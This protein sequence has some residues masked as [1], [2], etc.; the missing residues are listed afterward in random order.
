[1][2]VDTLLASLRKR[3]V[4]SRETAELTFAKTARHNIPAQ[5]ASQR[6]LLQ[7]GVNTAYLV[8]VSIDGGE[9]GFGLT[10]NRRRLLLHDPR[11]V[12]VVKLRAK[13]VDETRVQC[14]VWPWSGRNEWKAVDNLCRREQS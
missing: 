10:R 3:E 9:H 12:V 5:I 11:K 1:M 14:I 2:C 6:S 4:A 7:N 13:I 8:A